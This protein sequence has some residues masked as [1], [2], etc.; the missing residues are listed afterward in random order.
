MPEHTIFYIALLCQILLISVLLPHR[1]VS[2]VKQIFKD[3][4]R[5]SYPKLYPRPAEHYE[6]SHR[7]FRNANWAIA[8]VGLALIG[9]L[10]VTPRSGE[11]DHAIALWY[12]FL[13]AVPVFLLDLL[14]IR[15]ARL[16]RE[17][18]CTRKADLQPRRFLDAVSP[19]LL[20]WVGAT[21]VGF[22]GVIVYVNQFDFPWFG[23]YLNLLGVT[24]A[25]LIFAG[26]LYR[27]IYGKKLNPHQSTVDRMRHVK[28]LAR[29]L[30]LVSVAATVFTA[31]N[32][33]LAA[34][35]MRHLQP[36]MHSFYFQL[37]AVISCRIYLVRPSN[38][39]VYKAESAV[40]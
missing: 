32:I 19:A 28:T 15:E 11:W 7:S 18:S 27:Q 2:H 24:I 10:L 16:M 13:Q 39:E 25:N 34:A 31:L 12:F 40:G 20:G 23:G 30:A 36:A 4:P 29:I 21:F 37:L 3:Y 5:E 14:A 35:E 26:M 33:A 6:R 8:I 38:F 1:I 9:F 17:A 22:A